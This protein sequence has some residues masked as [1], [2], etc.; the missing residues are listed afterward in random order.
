MSATNYP[1]SDGLHRHDGLR[2]TLRARVPG[3]CFLIT[4]CIRGYCRAFEARVTLKDTASAR[5]Q[6]Y[7][8]QPIE[9]GYADAASASEMHTLLSTRDECK[10]ACGRVDQA[11]VDTPTRLKYDVLLSFCKGNVDFGT[12]LSRD[13]VTKISTHGQSMTLQEGEP[14]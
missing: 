10:P 1:P 2:C 3:L 11:F 5:K 4:A 9:P 7:A 8:K 6:M 13:N 12:T 14:C